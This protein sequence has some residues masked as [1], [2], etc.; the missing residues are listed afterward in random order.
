MPL[1]GCTACVRVYVCVTADFAVRNSCQATQGGPLS[2]GIWDLDWTIGNNSF[3]AIG[4]NQF[5]E[6]LTLSLF[7]G[8]F[9]SYLRRS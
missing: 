2:R 9:H 4:V 6:R 3:V 8:G 7:Q 5:N 1:E